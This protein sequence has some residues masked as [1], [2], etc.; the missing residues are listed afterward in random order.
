MY[1]NPAE[2]RCE[3]ICFANITAPQIC[4]VCF[5][6]PRQVWYLLMFGA[7][8]AH[9]CAHQNK[10]LAY[11]CAPSYVPPRSLAH[12][13]TC[14]RPWVFACFCACARVCVCVDKVRAGARKRERA[15]ETSTSV[16]AFACKVTHALF[17]C[18]IDMV[19][20][21]WGR[22]SKTYT[23]TYKWTLQ[24]HTFQRATLDKTN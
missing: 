4:V 20:R 11:L 17:S 18:V 7:P 9:S 23:P 6:N 1:I 5:W 2:Q 12:S 10:T 15:R 16:F 14:V 13:H 8:L 22:P 24:N 19:S 3:T 21:N